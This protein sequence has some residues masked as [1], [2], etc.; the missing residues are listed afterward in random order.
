MF[1]SKEN[2][3]NLKKMNQYI[4]KNQKHKIMKTGTRTSSSISSIATD[5]VINRIPKNQ[6]ILLS[7][8]LK[9]N[10]KPIKSLINT[11]E[12]KIENCT[13][14][15][16]IKTKN[17]YNI[18]NE[19]L[20]DDLLEIEGKRIINHLSDSIK[21]TNDGKFIINTKSLFSDNDTNIINNILSFGDKKK[22]KTKNTNLQNNNNKNLNKSNHINLFKEINNN[23]I[24]NKKTQNRIKLKTNLGY[25]YSPH[26]SINKKISNFKNINNN[27]NNI[28][29]SNKLVK[30]YVKKKSISND[31]Y[32]NII[33]QSKADIISYLLT[34]VS[35]RK[36]NKETSISHR[37]D[38]TKFIKETCFSMR[39]KQVNKNNIKDNKINKISTSSAS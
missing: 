29:N 27:N 33:N 38:N 37:N 39:E 19:N 1:I 36:N 17:K 13:T 8:D 10:S 4:T 3:K 9:G 7:P 35:Q 31:N 30:K 5:I 32:S 14:D 20:F 23:K 15:D 2:H 26:I 25:Y 28:V 6:K 24:K 21:I 16:N 12:Y 11:M 18:I 34:S 22:E